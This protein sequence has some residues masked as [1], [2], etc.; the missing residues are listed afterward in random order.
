MK[1]KKRSK[2]F[3]VTVTAIGTTRKGRKVTIPEHDASKSHHKN[4]RRRKSGQSPNPLTRCFSR[5][6]VCL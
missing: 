1:A 6:V 4:S 3:E 5:R 2:A